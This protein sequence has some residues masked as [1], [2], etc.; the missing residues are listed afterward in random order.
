MPR[1]VK[2]TSADARAWR[3]NRPQWVNKKGY[4][5]RAVTPEEE[6]ALF[7]AMERVKQFKQSGKVR[8]EAIYKVAEPETNRI[9]EQKVPMEV[10]VQVTKTGRD[11]LAYVYNLF[12]NGNRY[13]KG[14]EVLRSRILAKHGECILQ[15]PNGKQMAVLR[16]PRV[17]RPTFGESQRSA[18]AP[19]RCHCRGFKDN[20][21]AGRHHAACEWNV[22]A[23]PHERALPI[24]HAS[25]SRG[26]MDSATPVDGL[27]FEMLESSGMP[28]IP[29]TQ[30]M[31]TSDGRLIGSASGSVSQQG[32]VA[33]LAGP[34]VMSGP[35]APQAHAP[36]LPPP[37]PPGA[38]DE[39]A[40]A[41][42]YS[43][44]Q[45]PE[46]VT[47]ANTPRETVV[48]RRPEGL[49][50]PEK[51]DQDCRGFQSGT[52]G[53][54]WP[55]ARRPEDNQHHPFCKHADV[56]RVHTAGQKQW[57]LYDIDRKV[58]LRPA[59]A[60]EKARADV[61]AQRSGV[62]S[63]VVGDRIYAVI[64]SGSSPRPSAVRH[65]VTNLA[66]SFVRPTPDQDSL[67][68]PAAQA[69]GVVPTVT[70]RPAAA[71]KPGEELSLEE[72]QALI[73]RKRALSESGLPSLPSE[74]RVEAVL[75]EPVP[76]GEGALVM[77]GPGELPPSLEV[78]ADL[79]AE[80][81][82]AKTVLR[83]ELGLVGYQQHDGSIEKGFVDV[84][85]PEPFVDP[86]AEGAPELVVEALPSTALAS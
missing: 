81:L 57:M 59:T 41:P 44:P 84:V 3:E 46:G 10:V 7:P 20:P 36:A 73:D 74:A 18:P 55:Q 19:E 60:D 5:L 70:N 23:P 53:W 9:I 12:V 49:Q 54:E 64:L 32:G 82:P 86:I 35:S 85:D 37:P 13:V 80:T 52:K 71:S 75:A 30:S 8:V 42:V 21:D 79:P 27:A 14:R 39:P 63:V 50:S 43:A 29:N 2:L 40:Q 65:A 67:K 1:T 6:R 16:D 22:K 11:A 78:M 83:N 51:C 47:V 69:A 25:E 58:E 68:A 17:N 77:D 62:R 24:N 48:Q 56:W 15:G 33:A 26:L 34:V 45:R 72:L 38:D 76:T 31:R 66:G 61:E 28:A 4:V